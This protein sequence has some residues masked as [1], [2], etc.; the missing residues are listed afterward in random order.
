M[1]FARSMADRNTQAFAEFLAD[2]A[3][4][5]S[6]TTALRGKAKVIEGGPAISLTR[7]RRSPGRPIR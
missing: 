5:F 6:G 4:F 2:K 3:V 1:A 7:K